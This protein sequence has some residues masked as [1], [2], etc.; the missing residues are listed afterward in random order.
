MREAVALYPAPLG[1][2]Y[3]DFPPDDLREFIRQED[4]EVAQRLQ[5]EDCLRALG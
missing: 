5:F 4:H 3:F 1:P 2:G